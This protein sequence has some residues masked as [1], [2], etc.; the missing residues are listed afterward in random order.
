MDAADRTVQDVSFRDP[1]ASTLASLRP[2]GQRI[3]F[4]TKLAKIRYPGKKSRPNLASLA[5]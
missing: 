3:R 5:Q 1:V 2:W 4:L